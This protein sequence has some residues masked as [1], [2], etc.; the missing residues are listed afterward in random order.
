MRCTGM[1]D[2]VEHTVVLEVPKCFTVLFLC[3]RSHI[4]VVLHSWNT[5]IVPLRLQ[6][7]E[8]VLVP[9][10]VVVNSFFELCLDALD[11]VADYLKFLGARLCLSGCDDVHVDFASG[12]ISRRLL[13]CILDKHDGL[14]HI[15]LLDLFGEAHLGERLRDTD[16]GFKLPWRSRH[17]FRGISETT[18]FH[19]FL[20]QVHL[21][22]VWNLGSYALSG[23]RDILGK[24]VAVDA[25]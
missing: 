14:F 8:Q 3:E 21:N 15:A 11:V 20:Y 6:E 23:V 16:H 4:F 18:H 2:E 22:R 13:K 10:A 17:R 7:V 24:E 19:I 9:Q 1:T 25:V 5:S 12:W